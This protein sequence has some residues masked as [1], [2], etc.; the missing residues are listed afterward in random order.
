MQLRVFPGKIHR[1]QS[2]SC[3]MIDEVQKGTYDEA[4]LRDLEIGGKINGNHTG[5]YPSSSFNSE[6]EASSI[7][8]LNNGDVL[9]MREIN[10]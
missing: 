9:Y 10:R 4:T 6:T 2:G 3:P 5:E 8:K 1:P 7:I